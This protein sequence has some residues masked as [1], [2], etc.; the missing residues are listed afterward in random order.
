[1]RRGANGIRMIAAAR[2]KQMKT[3]RTYLMRINVVDFDGNLSPKFKYELDKNEFK[4]CFRFMA[5]LI[6]AVDWCCCC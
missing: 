3:I 4:F 6:V 5:G 2:I 1:M